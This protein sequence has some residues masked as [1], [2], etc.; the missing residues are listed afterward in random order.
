MQVLEILGEHT[1]IV[2]YGD[3][4]AL[5]IP[6]FLNTDASSSYLGPLDPFKPR[7]LLFEAAVNGDMQRYLNSY[8]HLINKGQ[9]LRWC[10]EATE[11]LSYYH[12]MGV[13]HCDLRLD[14]L[15]LNSNLSV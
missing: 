4:V 1:R 8:G 9:S 11:G 10:T 2:W 15:L 13:L 5:S 12:R 3:A 6:M 14:N 7:D